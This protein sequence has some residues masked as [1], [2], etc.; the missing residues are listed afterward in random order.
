MF[1]DRPMSQPRGLKVCSPQT[2]V[3]VQRAEFIQLFPPVCAR[4]QGRARSPF[5]CAL[6]TRNVLREARHASEAQK[7][8][9]GVLTSWG[10]RGQGGCAMSQHRVRLRQ[11]CSGMLGHQAALALMI[12]RVY[13]KS[14]GHPSPLTAAF[15]PT[16]PSFFS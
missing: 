7:R 15:L 8:G 11:C 10:R 3:W 14:S 16:A 13:L 12:F 6:A 4:G 2:S 9:G 1:V 5:L